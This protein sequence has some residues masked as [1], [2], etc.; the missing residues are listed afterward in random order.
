[1]ST[2]Y[3]KFEKDGYLP[4]ETYIIRDEEIDM[5]AAIG[6]IFLYYPWLW[7]FKYYPVHKYILTPIN[8]NQNDDFYYG[9]DNPPDNQNVTNQTT[10]VPQ[11]SK[12]QKLMELKE[13]YDNGILSEDEYKTEKQKILDNDDW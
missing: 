6:G 1:M 4:L 12:A 11:K 10:N 3:I 5:T 2:T 8:D 13:L 9:N 7:L